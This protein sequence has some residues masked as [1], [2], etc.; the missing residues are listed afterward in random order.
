MKVLET[1]RRRMVSRAFIMNGLG[2][3]PL[4]CAGRGGMEVWL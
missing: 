2:K 1:M 3:P 4:A